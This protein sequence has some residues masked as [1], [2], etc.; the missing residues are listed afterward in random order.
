M[1]HPSVLYI[2]IQPTTRHSEDPSRLRCLNSCTV[3]TLA[4]HTHTHSVSPGIGLD[5]Q[6]K[7]NHTRIGCEIIPNIHR[8]TRQNRYKISMSSSTPVTMSPEALSC[9]VP[10]T[11]PDP[12]IG[13]VIA[14][15]RPDGKPFVS[16]EYFPPRTAE[17]VQVRCGILYCCLHNVVVY[18]RCWLCISHSIIYIYIYLCKR[19]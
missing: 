10:G 16:L 13:D 7:N 19:V 17:G 12:R 11:T 6:L 14:Q 15:P 9:V 4:A 5:P 3:V 1:R 18:C 2:G 8:S